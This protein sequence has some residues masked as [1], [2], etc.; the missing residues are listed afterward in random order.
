M[1]VD[2][3]KADLATN[4]RIQHEPDEAIQHPPISTLKDGEPET[5]EPDKISIH[6]H[7]SIATIPPPSELAQHR[8]S[9]S[10]TPSTRSRTPTAI[11]RSKRRGLFGRFT[12]VPE[13]ENAKEHKRSIKWFITMLVALAAAAAP[14]GSAIFLRKLSVDS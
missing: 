14:M 9:K 11:P 1:A 4:D 2:L 7:S 12:L 13:I 3:E 10:N 5:E 8:R 6:S